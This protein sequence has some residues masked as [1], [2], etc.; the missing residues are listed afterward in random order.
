MSKASAQARERGSVGIMVDL[1]GKRWMD[2]ECMAG[3]VTAP[4]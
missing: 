2:G 3:Y 4:S 1:M